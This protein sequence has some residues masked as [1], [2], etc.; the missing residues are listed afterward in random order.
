MGA[1]KDQSSYKQTDIWKDRQ[2][3]IRYVRTNIIFTIPTDRHI[4]F[5]FTYATTNVAMFYGST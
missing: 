5:P 1:R 3:D 2:A 4:Y